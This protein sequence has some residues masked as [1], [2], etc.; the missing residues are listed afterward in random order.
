MKKKKT[1]RRGRVSLGRPTKTRVQGAGGSK[2]T[3]PELSERRHGRPTGRETLGAQAKQAKGI[4]QMRRK[5][6]KRTWTGA[7][8]LSRGTK[9]EKKNNPLKSHRLGFG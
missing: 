1:K 9:S 5:T 3:N 2:N 6:G 8:S 4:W 7:R